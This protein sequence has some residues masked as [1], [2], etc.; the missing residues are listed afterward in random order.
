VALIVQLR[1]RKRSKKTLAVLV[2]ILVFA[3]VIG[4]LSAFTYAGPSY[5][6]VQGN[7]HMTMDHIF[8]GTFSPVTKRI[9]WVKEG[10]HHF[11]QT[12]CCMLTVPQLQMGHTRM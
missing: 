7:K 10:K 2:G 12:V 1:P 3:A 9:D 11:S 4:A 5:S 8:N 6:V